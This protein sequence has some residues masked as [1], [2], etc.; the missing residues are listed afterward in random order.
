V[1]EQGQALLGAGR[2]AARLGAATAAREPLLRAR[3][4]FAHLGTA[5]LLAETDRLLARTSS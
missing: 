2:C 1:L 3:A 5:A 4:I